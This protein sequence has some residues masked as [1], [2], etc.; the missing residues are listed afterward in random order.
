MSI[1]RSVRVGIKLLLESI[2]GDL[3]NPLVCGHLKHCQ[4]NFHATTH[5]PASYFGCVSV[6]VY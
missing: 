1:N 6:F 3:H 5:P 4:Q 2:W